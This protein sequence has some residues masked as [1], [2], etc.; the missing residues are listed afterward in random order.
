MTQLTSFL[1]K[2]QCTWK[3]YT[4]KWTCTVASLI[5]NRLWPWLVTWPVV[6]LFDKTMTSTNN[7]LDSDTQRHFFLTGRMTYSFTEIWNF[8]YLAQNFVLVRN[9]S[10]KPREAGSRV[11]QI[12]C[13]W[14][15][16]VFGEKGVVIVRFLTDCC[17]LVSNWVYYHKVKILNSNC[18]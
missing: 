15:L 5:S 12:F 16:L 4:Q 10:N 1:M 14:W 13:W 17:D 7:C 8:L 9:Q 18:E 2:C 3:M 6:G 11:S